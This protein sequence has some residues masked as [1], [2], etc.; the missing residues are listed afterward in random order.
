M[1]HR[2]SLK[3]GQQSHLWL[4]SVDHT[5]DGRWLSVLHTYCAHKKLCANSWQ[6]LVCMLRT[7]CQ[8]MCFQLTS[9]LSP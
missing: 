7:C 5:C 8:W 2:I 4:A 9:V 6:L 3:C 1:T